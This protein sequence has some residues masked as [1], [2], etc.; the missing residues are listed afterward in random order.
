MADRSPGRIVTA[1]YE[2]HKRWPDQRVAQ[3]IYNAL[4]TAG[5]GSEDIFYVENDVLAQA[6]FDYADIKK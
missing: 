3:L 5:I 1:I 6:L 4:D 2:A